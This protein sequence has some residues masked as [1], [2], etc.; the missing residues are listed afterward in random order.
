MFSQATANIVHFTKSTIEN[1]AHVIQVQDLKN[2]TDAK[3]EIDFTDSILKSISGV[4]TGSGSS[5]QVKFTR[6]SFEGTAAPLNLNADSNS[7]I[8]LTSNFTSFKGSK[9]E[10]KGATG[11]VSL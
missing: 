9:I 8:T 10:I 2:Y 1:T 11:T 6:S 7:L 3:S 4:S 5:T